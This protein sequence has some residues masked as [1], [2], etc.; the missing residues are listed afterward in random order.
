MSSIARRFNRA[1]L[2][3]AHD[4]VMAAA[5]YLLSLYLRLG[6]AL[7]SYAPE[8]LLQ[9]TALFTCV[10]AALFWWTG[11][12]RGVWRY[13][14]L[15]DLVAITR[16]VTLAILIFLSLQFLATRLV[17]VPRS[18]LIIDWFVLIMLLGGPRF[19]Y[20]ILKDRGTRFVLSR[21]SATRIPVLLLGAGDGAELFVR[22]M[23]RDPAANYRVV[24]IVG[25]KATRIGRKIHGVEVLG[26]F[27]AIQDVI[28]RLD[29]RGERPQRMIITK[30]RLEG[31]KVRALL[32]LAERLGIALSRLPRLTDFKSGAGD[33]LE[34]RPIAIEDLLGRPQ[35]VLD[36]DAM[37]ALVAGR[38]V[39][40][41]GA[42][43]TI[44]SELVR[45][46]SDLGPARVALLD[47]GEFLLYAID[48]ELARRHA[49]LSRAPILA[50]VRDRNRL[51]EVMAAEAPE[52]VFHAAALKHVPMV[53]AHPSEGVLTNVVGT[54]NVAD[55]CAEAGVRVM[56]QISTDKAVNPTN[57]MGAT[58]RL[59]E[60]YCQAR[61]LVA[62]KRA[63]GKPA[64]TRFL[65][66]RFGNVLASAGSVVP[67]FQRQLEAGEPLTVTHAEVA[68]YIMTVREAVELV[69]QASAL[70]GEPDYAQGGIFVLNM[71]EPVRI[72]DLAKQMIRLAGLRP[73]VDVPIEI[74][75]LRPGEKLREELFHD[76]ERPQPTECKGILLAAS[77]AADHA[78]IARAIDELA[79][80]A[81]L[82]RSEQVLELLRRL[83]PEYRPQWR[84]EDRARPA[85]PSAAAGP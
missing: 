76:A 66:V 25:E 5:S 27:A 34:I 51:D 15:N 16:A 72:L 2:A 67:L 28:E 39:L 60:N 31:A 63:G 55:A 49:G 57:V 7:F 26:D 14:S 82:G 32:D 70:G 40:V 75:G 79:E 85:P 38:R 56:V 35:T 62:G 52:L 3:F 78:L 23:R 41:T 50:D 20:R 48:R 6:D 17:D 13:A 30:D 47:N 61:D 83:V 43:G 73:E 12:Y 22:E 65:T 84:P 45:Q 69:L 53:E 19:V 4:I 1:H 21:E 11:M 10:A 74:T 33:K 80:A 81:R 54:R 58:K 37:R 24:G 59:A 36:R 77:R 8:F 44:G 46:I 42:G 71:G 9:T 18:A 68:R 29:A 64:G